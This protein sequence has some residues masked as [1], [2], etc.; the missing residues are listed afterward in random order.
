MMPKGLTGIVHFDPWVVFQLDI[1]KN[2]KEIDNIFP[3]NL[4][5]TDFWVR[6]ELIQN[7]PDV[8]QALTDTYVESVL[9]SRLKHDDSINITL[10]DPSY[11]FFTKEMV[12]TISSVWVEKY[13]PTWMYVHKDF[14]TKEGVRVADWLHQR[15][16]FR[17]KITKEKLIS[18]YES[19][20]MDET[21]MRV[22][23]AAPEKPTWLP[24]NWAG[25]AGKIPYPEYYNITNLKKPLPFPE[26]SDLRKAWYFNG[27][28]FN[29]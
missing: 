18:F 8:V 23:W 10:K 2:A 24:K 11:K 20:F 22:G 26:K 3:Y 15:G 14:W 4:F 9:W 19:K 25:E 12:Y 21:F 28:W 13:K 29:P 7:V 6:D 17:E 5:E 16:R 27:Q 1:Q